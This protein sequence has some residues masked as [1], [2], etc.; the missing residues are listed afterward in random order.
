MIMVLWLFGVFA[1]VVPAFNYHLI[2]MPSLAS[3][4]VANFHL[5]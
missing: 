5:M 1:A 3:C 4:A 2:V